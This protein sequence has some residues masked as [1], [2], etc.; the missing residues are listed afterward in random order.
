MS[1]LREPLNILRITLTIGET[2]APYNQFSLAIA[3]KHNITICNYFKSNITPPKEITLF[4]GDD[5]LKGFFRV[6]KAAFDEREYDIVHAHTGHVGVFFLVA[7]ILYGRFA[8]PTVF[9]VHNSYQNYKLRNKLLLIPAFAFFQR[10]VCCGQASFE[11]F[12]GFFKWLADDRFCFVQNG[13]D[14]DRIDRVI[15]KNQEH[16]Q[17]SYFTITTVGRLIEIKYPLSVLKAFQQCADQASR[18][19]FIGEGHMRGDLLTEIE[20]SGFGNQVELTGLIPRDKVYEQLTRANL[21]ISTSAGE[22]FPIAVLE[23]MACRCPVLLSD[24]PPHREINDGVDFIPL[25]HPDDVKGFARE[26]K[27]FRQMS[28]SERGEIGEKCRRLVE[29]RF[30]L[31]TMHRE[32][33]KVYSQVLGKCKK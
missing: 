20:A 33:E 25:I 23:A 4:E 31:T 7:N 29:K 5:S 8:C 3:T 21:F 19:V 12:P 28:S 32:Y 6:L 14:I 15:G 22:G 27:R 18:L 10:V 26:I 24:I 17:N 2:S 16:V 13:V 30:S 9:T 1:K 11:S